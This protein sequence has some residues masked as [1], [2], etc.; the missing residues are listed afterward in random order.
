MSLK[1]L[2]FIEYLKYH[3]LLVVTGVASI[4]YLNNVQSRKQDELNAKLLLPVCL[5][6]CWCWHT[7]LVIHQQTK[8][9]LVFIP[10]VSQSLAEVVWTLP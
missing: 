7:T 6:L 1:T 9:P 2:L 10:N 8:G 5:L 3:H 4:M